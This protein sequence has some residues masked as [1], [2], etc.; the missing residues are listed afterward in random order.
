[1]ATNTGNGFRRGSVD[2]RSQ[3]QAPNG[4]FVKRDTNTG[5]FIEQK[6][7]DGSF[8]GVAQEKDGAEAE[9]LRTAG[10]FR[11]AAKKPAALRNRAKSKIS[12][13]PT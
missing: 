5:R 6:T 1:M 13:M 11:E 8:K 7:T 9:R 4:N 10:S 2:D 12:A 3:F